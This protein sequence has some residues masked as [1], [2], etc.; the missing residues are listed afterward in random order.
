MIFQVGKYGARI[1]RDKG[2]LAFEFRSSVD[3]PDQWLVEYAGGHPT[4][5]G[6]TMT[7]R[8]AMQVSGVYCAVDWICKSV[9]RAPRRLFE[10]L[11]DDESRIAIEHPVDKLLRHPPNPEMTQKTFW[12]TVTAHRLLWGNGYAEIERDGA[13]RPVALWPLRP[14]RTFPRRIRTNGKPSTWPL[15]YEVRTSGG[16]EVTLEPW[17]V[18][19]VMGYSY[20]GLRGLSPIAL[21][22]ETLGLS[23]ATQDYGARFF[24]NDARPGGVLTTPGKL[25]KEAAARLKA[26]WDEAHRGGAQS[27]RV[28]VLE[29]DVKWQTIG[30]P[31]E[32][33]QYLQTRVFQLSEIARMYHF[34]LHMLAE[35]T[36]ATFSNIEHQRIEVIEDAST[37]EAFGIEQEIARKLLTEEE[38]ERFYPEHDF[39][40]QKRGDQKS[41]NEADDIEWRNGWINTDEIRS[42]R[43]RNA[44]PNGQGKKY[45][46]PVTQQPLDLALNPPEPAA[47]LG[48]D[49]KP[50]KPP[51]GDAPPP[52]AK[53]TKRD[54]AEQRVLIAR[55]YG[56]LLS[57]VGD[58]LSR[59]ELTALSRIA[60][61]GN[62]ASDPSADIRSFFAEHRSYVGGAL[63]P[64]LMT[65]EESI[66]LMTFRELDRK[67]EASLRDRDQ[68]LRQYVE[69]AAKRYTDAALSHCLRQLPWAEGTPALWKNEAMRAVNAF[70]LRCYVAAGVEKIQWIGPDKWMA[71][72]PEDICERCI[73]LDHKRVKPGEPFTLEMVNL[74]HPPLHDGCE[75]QIV[76]VQI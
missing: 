53:P 23:V 3:E 34:P 28:A 1:S 18:F 52:K 25:G 5:S 29:Q 59:K 11:S 47:K 32:D 20:D 38:R 24:G 27:H 16:P 61:S 46:V 68:F 31:N 66:V 37:P 21:H 42:K 62:P 6:Q 49:G 71:A 33:A 13:G 15:V 26:S 22:R 30:M 41:Q 43:R 70:A 8:T 76:A 65:I 55:S 54:I 72:K 7:E 45:F 9:S 48:P 12:E 35:L 75:C 17:Q 40:A 64:I 73:S 74:Q 44:L 69:S 10:R 36:H 63:Q 67:F 19:H 58:R 4:S 14:D 60:K 50:V 2:R 51:Q 57:Q 56:V 39:S